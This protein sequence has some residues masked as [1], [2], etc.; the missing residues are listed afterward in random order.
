MSF[1]PQP[2]PLEDS[3]A[4]NQMFKHTT[5]ITNLTIQLIVEFSKRV[6]GFATLLMCD[7]IT[8][9]KGCSGELMM[10]RC[11]R[12][13]DIRTNRIVYATTRCHTREDHRKAS[14]GD[15][16]DALF[17][18]C[19]SMCSLRLDNEEYALLTAIILFSGMLSQFN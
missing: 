12:K 5:E 6:P 3:E 10:L 2:Y 9:L 14:V 16:T 1:R 7:Q 11:S 8:L 17:D 19:R 15:T 18:F 13:Y 4:Y